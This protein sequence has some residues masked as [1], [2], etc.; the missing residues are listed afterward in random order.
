MELQRMFY[1]ASISAVC[2]ASQVRFY[3]L[4]REICRCVCGPGIEYY[5]AL[6]TREE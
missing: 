6:S 3:N 2:E 5:R 4:D 1:D